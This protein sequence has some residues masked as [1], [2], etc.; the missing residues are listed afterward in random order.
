MGRIQL[1]TFPQAARIIGSL[2]VTKARRTVAWL[3]I[4][5]Y[6]RKNPGYRKEWSENFTSAVTQ[7]TE[8]V[9][10]AVAKGDSVAVLDIRSPVPPGMNPVEVGT[11]FAWRAQLVAQERLG[12]MLESGELARPVASQADQT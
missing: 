6:M 8:S 1:D 3:R 11:V 9:K 12:R 4:Q 7:I 2:R 5:L 10:N